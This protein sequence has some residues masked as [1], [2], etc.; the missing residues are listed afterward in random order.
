M[1]GGVIRFGGDLDPVTVPVEA[2][3]PVTVGM[4]P[5]PTPPAL[6]NNTDKL[7]KP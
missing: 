7:G 1:G 4:L 3:L 5:T 6:L 2:F